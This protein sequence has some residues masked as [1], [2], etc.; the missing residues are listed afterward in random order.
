M[1]LGSLCYNILY[2]HVSHIWTFINVYLLDWIWLYHSSLY[3]LCNVFSLLK[4]GLL[5]WNWNLGSFWPKMRIFRFNTCSIIVLLP[6]HGL[7]MSLG[8]V[9]SQLCTTIYNERPFLCSYS[10]KKWNLRLFSAKKGD[11][12]TP[13]LFYISI[14]ASTWARHITWVCIDTFIYHYI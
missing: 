8:F 2:K 11:I 4:Q 5:N 10:F 12:S 9:Q 14:I 13:H 6:L 1:R 7:G 3:F